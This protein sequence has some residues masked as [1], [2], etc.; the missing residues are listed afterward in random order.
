MQ[1]PYTTNGLNQYTNAGGVGFTYDANGNLIADGTNTFVYDVENRLVGRTNG[2]VVLTYDPLG[3][4][5]QVSSTSG[6]TTQFLYDGDALVAEY[7]SGTMTQRYAHNAG[8]DVPML[9][10]TY[11]NGVLT[12]LD[13]LHAD[14]QGSIIALSDGSTG[15]AAIN[16]YDE[17]GIPVPDGAGGWI[18]RLIGV[19][20]AGAAS[21]RN[22]VSRSNHD[23]SRFPGRFA[24]PVHARARRRA[25]GDGRHAAGRHRLRGRSG[26]H[27]AD[28]RPGDLPDALAAR[29]AGRAGHQDCGDRL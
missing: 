24:G 23:E 15:A 7:V 5:F 9:S 27:R 25:V 14:R 8:A 28:R 21:G 6:P 20:D 11:A 2:N 3:R 16:R 1:R 17:Y 4:L 13:Y 18:G 12:R 10:D 29:H 26:K 22:R 19:C